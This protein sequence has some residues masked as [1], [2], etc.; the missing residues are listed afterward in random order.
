MDWGLFA[1]N[2]LRPE[3]HRA[4]S[5]YAQHVACYKVGS[6]QATRFTACLICRSNPL[7]TDE[8]LGYIHDPR[9]TSV[10][11]RD[12]YIYREDMTDILP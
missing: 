11:I 1:V 6:T 8:M 3:K 2:E 4:P 5:D 7:S 10:H 9:E 12:S